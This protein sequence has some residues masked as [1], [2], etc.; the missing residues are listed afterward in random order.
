MWKIRA[1]L[2]QH[3]DSG[4]IRQRLEE[5]D[6]QL[7]TAQPLRFFIGRLSDLD[8]RVPAPRLI[9]KLCTRLAVRL[10][11]ERSCRSSPALDDHLKPASNQFRDSLRDERHSTLARLDLPRNAD[12]HRAIL[13]TLLARD[14]FPRALRAL[15]P[16]RDRL[17]RVRR[18]VGSR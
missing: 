8:D 6:Q 11:G 9:R 10:V 13:R 17:P 12:S 3:F 4:W 16:V 15:V 18:P 14:P 1:A 5:P 2:R 7:P